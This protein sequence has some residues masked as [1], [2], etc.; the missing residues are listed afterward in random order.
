MRIWDSITLQTTAVL[1]LGDANFERA[2]SCVAFSKV[3]G[4]A[5]LAAVDD[6]YEHTLSIWD[7]QRKKKITETKVI[8]IIGL[9]TLAINGG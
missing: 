2:V 1:G 3:D 8:N 4:G 9:K 6:S 5:L 7:W